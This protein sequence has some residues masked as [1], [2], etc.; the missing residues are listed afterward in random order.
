MTSPINV[1]Q[2][3]FQERVLTASVP[4]LVDFWAEWCG[5]CKAMAPVLDKLAAE[6]GESLTVAKVNVD[7]E[8][9]IAAALGIRSLP[10]MMLFVGGQPVEQIV[11]AQPEANIRA[12][13]D[14]HVD[15]DA[16]TAD[17]AGAPEAF[18]AGGE[19][20]LERLEQ[21]LAENPDNSAALI[22]IARIRILHGELDDAETMLESLQGDDRE[23]DDAKQVIAALAFA[24]LS[25]ATTDIESP[26]QSG[27]A[28]PAELKMLLQ[29]GDRRVAE[30]DYDGAAEQ[31]LEVLQRDRQFDDQAGRG[32][33]ILL[34]DL[35]G[36]ADARV[37]QLRRRM[38]SALY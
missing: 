36:P 3:D 25:G 6:Y 35:L 16:V 34:F 4:V 9:E 28:E 13:I 29:R 17:A 33:L 8:Q 27:A 31:Y 20:S 32:R 14:Q 11:G 12:V 15:L 2:H 24:R 1:T 38:M 22:A 37:A 7:E 23:T 30:G 26:E 5:P 19:Q 18:D 10:T 21:L